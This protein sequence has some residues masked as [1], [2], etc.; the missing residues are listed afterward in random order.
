MA[1]KLGMQKYQHSLSK[2]LQFMELPENYDVTSHSVEWKAIDLKFGVLPTFV[3]TYFPTIA[4][5]PE[6]F[7]IKKLVVP[8]MQVKPS[9]I[10]NNR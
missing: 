9:L 3:F 10:V 5:K 6:Y 8:V 7:Y 2:V 1:E 4:V